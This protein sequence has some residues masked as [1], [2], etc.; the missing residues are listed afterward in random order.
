MNHRVVFNQLMWLCIIVVF[1]SFAITQTA[2]AQAPSQGK[3]VEM[4]RASFQQYLKSFG[5]KTRG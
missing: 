5:Y 2:S 3:I 4:D 1:A